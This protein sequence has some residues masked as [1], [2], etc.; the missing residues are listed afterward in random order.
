MSS[1]LPVDKVYESRRVV[2]FV[3][4][5]PAYR[6]HSLILPKQPL[7]SLMDISAA[8]GELLAEITLAAQKLVRRLHLEESGYRLIVNGGEYQEIKQL[9]F[10]LVAD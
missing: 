9:H 1:F 8:D 3:H 7:S 6:V 2:A 10:H 5:Q 4:P